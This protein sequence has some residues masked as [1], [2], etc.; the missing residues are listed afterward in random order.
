MSSLTL[1]RKGGFVLTAFLRD[2][3]SAILP[4]H[5]HKKL[6]FLIFVQDF[7]PFSIHPC[8]K[9]VTTFLFKREPFYHSSKIK[10][11]N[12]KVKDSIWRIAGSQMIVQSD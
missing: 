2:L 7:L 11:S 5:A 6:A 4:L 10:F 12:L 8:P 3:Y 9:V 1:N